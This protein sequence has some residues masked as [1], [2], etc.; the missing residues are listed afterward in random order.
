VPA[1]VTESVQLAL[2]D[3]QPVHTKFV[4]LFVH[5]AETVIV[6]PV[7]GCELVDES[8]HDGVAA[9]ARQFTEM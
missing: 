4:G 3:V 7:C 6:V 5:D 8:V 2:L 1:A 9:A